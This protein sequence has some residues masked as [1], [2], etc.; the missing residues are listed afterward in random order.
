MG[1]HFVC[2]RC[3]Y[4]LH[5]KDFQAGKRGKCPNCKG[6]F[7]IPSSDSSY[8]S[9]IEESTESSGVATIREAFKKVNSSN[10][11]KLERKP[12]DS[13]AISIELLD[14]GNDA[15]WFVRLPSGEQIGPAESQLLMRWIAESRVT[16][17]SFLWR[18]GM[19]AW[20]SANALVPEFFENVK[21]ITP[22]DLSLLPSQKASTDDGI[23][24][25]TDVVLSEMSSLVPGALLKKRM[26]KR[27]QQLRMVI[28]LATVSLIL[29]SILI[30]VLVFQINPTA[31]P[32]L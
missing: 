25:D 8:S 17:D 24:I 13:D 9:A 11:P 32:R 3:S 22:S 6:S 12:S 29:L 16:A 18:E 4:G 31:P 15:K 14:I 10:E 2:H 5:V 23:A 27:R 19:E 1:I 21:Q 28:V 7:R 26:Q 30:F 20:Q